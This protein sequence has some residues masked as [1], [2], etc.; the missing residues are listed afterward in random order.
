VI[1]ADNQQVLWVGEGSNRET[2]RP[3]FEWLGPEACSTSWPS[4][5]EK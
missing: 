1:N 2:M 5:A 4:S 3:F